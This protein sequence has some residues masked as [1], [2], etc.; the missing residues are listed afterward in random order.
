MLPTMAQV[1]HI[2][3]PVSDIAVSKE[4]YVKKFG[5]SF[6]EENITPEQSIVQL[7][8]SNGDTIMLI[9]KSGMSRVYPNEHYPRII[10]GLEVQKLDSL[11]EELEK[12][13]VKFESERLEADGLRMLHVR[14]PDGHVFQL[15]EVI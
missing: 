6:V 9:H 14:D 5:M 11:K 13:G 8:T 2:W 4:F 7:Q 15:T 3:I 12:R 10:I 1:T